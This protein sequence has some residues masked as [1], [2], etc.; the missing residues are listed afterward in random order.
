MVSL[1][2]G[3]KV[4]KHESLDGIN[5]CG[6]QMQQSRS[7]Y[8]FLLVGRVGGVAMCTYFRVEGQALLSVSYVWA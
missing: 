7:S 8:G 2:I 1:C 3:C 5:I 4:C 6:T